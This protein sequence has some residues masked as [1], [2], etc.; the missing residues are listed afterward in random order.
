MSTPLQRR[1]SSLSLL[2]RRRRLAVCLVSPSPDALPHRAACPA[3]LLPRF[4]ASFG[5]DA[6]L[7]VTLLRFHAVPSGTAAARW[8]PPSRRAAGRALRCCCCGVGSGAG[9]LR[10][11]APAAAAGV[12]ALALGVPWGAVLRRGMALA[13]PQPRGCGAGG[14]RGTGSGEPRCG[15]TSA[16]AV[17]F[18]TPVNF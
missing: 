5:G 6:A 15:S 16:V 13:A 8:S 1:R 10:A 12:G 3:S 17:R 14:G 4:F 7:F 11:L 18:L 2:P 9:R